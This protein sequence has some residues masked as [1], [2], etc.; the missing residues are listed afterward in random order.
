MRLILTIEI[1]AHPANLKELEEEIKSH[2]LELV[3]VVDIKLEAP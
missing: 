2:L 1:E 3:D